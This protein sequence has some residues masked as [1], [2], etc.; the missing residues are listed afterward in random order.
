MASLRRGECSGDRFRSF[1]NTVFGTTSSEL[2][3]SA[4]DVLLF[5][6]ATPRRR[7]CSPTF[8]NGVRMLV[9]WLVD[10]L[11]PVNHKGL[12]QG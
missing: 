1:P 8:L 9:G 3:R 7:Q 4:G 10:A 2:E 12:Y 5:D 6:P 11:I